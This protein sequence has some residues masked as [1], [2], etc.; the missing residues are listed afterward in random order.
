MDPLTPIL[1][2]PSA[3][4][5]GYQGDDEDRALAWNPKEDYMDL[6]YTTGPGDYSDL[7]ELIDEMN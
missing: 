3:T 2:G 6:E 5:L 4:G 1:F 7:P